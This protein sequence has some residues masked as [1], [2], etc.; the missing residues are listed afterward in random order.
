MTVTLDTIEQLAA[1]CAALVREGVTFT[2]GPKPGRDGVFIV[3][4]TG[5]F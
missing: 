2:A 3:T 5:G 1:F 4:F